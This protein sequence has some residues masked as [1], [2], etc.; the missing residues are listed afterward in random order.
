[1]PFVL[2]LGFTTRAQRALFSDRAKELAINAEVHYLNAPKDVRKKR[3]EKR[4]I[5]K[6]P[7]VYAFEVTNMM[8]DFM[9]P[10]FEIPTQEELK[11]GC[12]VTT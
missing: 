4:N 9:E 5:E 3:V 12:E 2:D 7:T 8:F 1:M 10:K 6:D 11:N